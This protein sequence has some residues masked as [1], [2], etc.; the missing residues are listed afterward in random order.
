M[1]VLHRSAKSR[2]AGPPAA[3]PSLREM[4]ERSVWLPLLLFVLLV[5]WAWVKVIG[6]CAIILS[7]RAVTSLSRSATAA[8]LGLLFAIAYLFSPYWMIP[9]DASRHALGPIIGNAPAAWLAAA[10]LFATGVFW[11]WSSAAA[12]SW[13]GEQADRRSYREVVAPLLLAVFVIVVNFAPL[14]YSVP[15]HGDERW[16]MGRLRSF[17]AGLAPLFEVRNLPI[18]LTVIAIVGAFLAL[19]RRPAIHLRVL[20]VCAAGVAAAVSMGF[21]G[22]PNMQ[23]W[24]IRYPFFSSWFQVIGAVWSASLYDEG[25]CRVVPLTALFAI[26]YFVL[27]ALRAGNVP[28]WSA[29]AAAL[30]V[31]TIPNLYYH[32]TIL[33][34]EMPAVALLMVCLYYIE[35]LLADD[36]DDVRTCP[37]WYA[38]LAM[39]FVKETLVAVIAAVILLRIIVRVSIIA[40]RSGPRLRSFAGEFLVCLCMSIPLG[41][42]LF[43]RM[44]FANLRSYTPRIASL[45]DW[46][47]Y[48][49]AAHYLWLH[50]GI[51]LFLAAAGLA[52][53]LLKRRFL[54]A[55][56]LMT[57]FAVDFLFHLMDDPECIG[58]A[59][60]S[61][62][63]FAPLMAMS[64]AFLVW[65]AGRHR[66]AL[67]AVAA[68][69]LAANFVMSPV[70]IGGE[71]K[72]YWI[73]S[74]TS[75]SEFYFSKR[76]AVTWLRDN[77]PDWPIVTAGTP[78]DAD[79]KWYFR[80]LGYY[81]PSASIE[82]KPGVSPSENLRSAIAA[83]SA[84]GAPL[85]LYFRMT[86][87]TELSDEERKVGGYDA[88][89]VFTNRY[90]A[91]IL[92]QASS[93]RR[94]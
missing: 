32:A 56:S 30:A 20:L 41:V 71:K 18:T 28:K 84:S 66:S 69:W 35:P 27:R 65:L 46:S 72:P 58:L 92:Y 83:A 64:I 5:P 16:H 25:A 13:R 89:E 9:C 50:F 21:L 45:F 87:G 7:L 88:A 81:P 19:V 80:Q 24:V 3:R 42:Y 39:G 43:M 15:I 78:V 75:L 79:V 91:I 49:T 12:V 62:T 54:Y 68:V 31:V 4:M 2:G 48:A 82:A 85:V 60:F 37:G 17:H 34:L 10:L 76:Q 94:P 1:T 44:F 6:C 14:Y 8:L 55:L 38:F 93:S 86:P 74:N 70:A 73:S 40:R 23:S 53:L 77:R 57:I 29:L 11:A 36:P 52:V 33:Y 61:L 67:A 22:S 63:L 90:L 47:L 59:R 26:G 51:L